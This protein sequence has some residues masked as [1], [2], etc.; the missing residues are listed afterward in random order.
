MNKNL[1]QFDDVPKERNEDILS[2]MNN[3]KV[4]SSVFILTQAIQDSILCIRFK[5]IAMYRPWQTNSILKL[6]K[7]DVV[8]PLRFTRCS[9][10]PCTPL[11]FGIGN[12]IQ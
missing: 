3:N 6:E 9:P 12:L 10:F 2:S 11:R 5:K 4:T 7:V 8:A 1:T